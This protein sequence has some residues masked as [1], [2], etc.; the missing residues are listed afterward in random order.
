MARRICTDPSQRRPGFDTS[1]CRICVVQWHWD[2]VFS[3]YL[4]F[5]LSA[6]FHHCTLLIQ[7][8]TTNVMYSRSFEMSPLLNNTKTLTIADLFLLPSGVQFM[9]LVFMWPQ[10]LQSLRSAFRALQTDVSAVLVHSPFYC[11]FTVLSGG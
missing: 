11:Y 5:S 2:R 8:S 3:A 6:S 9:F 1:P 10:N 4:F 7:S